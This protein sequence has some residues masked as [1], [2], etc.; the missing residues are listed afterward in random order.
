[1][2]NENQLTRVSHEPEFSSVEEG[3]AIRLARSA[4]EWLHS[5][6]IP[7]QSFF[8]TI[9]LNTMRDEPVKIFMPTP[10]NGEVNPVFVHFWVYRS[11]RN[12]F[13][14]GQGNLYQY[15]NNYDEAL[16][17]HIHNIKVGA[18]SFVKG[19]AGASYNSAEI[20][21]SLFDRDLAYG[22][23]VVMHEPFHP[24]ISTAFE[25]NNLED[26]YLVNESI[27]T[28]LG[29]EALR[30]YAE[31]L[32]DSN[33]EIYRGI[34]SYIQ[35]H[36]G[37]L[38]FSRL[39]YF[40]LKEQYKFT[41]GDE[42]NNVSELLLHE[43]KTYLAKIEAN[44]DIGTVRVNEV[45]NARIIERLS[46]ATATLVRDF[47]RINNI[48]FMDFVHNPSIRST[49]LSKIQQYIQ[50]NYDTPPVDLEIRWREMKEE[51]DNGTYSNYTVRSYQ[52]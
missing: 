49:H 26:T 46:Y 3:I 14:E 35:Q 12:K 51:I 21:R 22:L 23:M 20:S 32:R 39:A 27:T 4:T 41:E 38:E 42:R 47:F 24:W 52:R 31:E 50:G 6:G 48:S 25:N 18:D 7:T 43:V 2:S 17:A 34:Q 45:N 30:L 33:P 11:D 5:I 8:Q 40:L 13:P 15:Y 28:Y 19:A 29:L 9:A 37:I 10:V 36:L 16:K 1:M 44:P